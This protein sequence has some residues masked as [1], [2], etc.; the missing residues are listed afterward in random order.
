MKKVEFA[1]GFYAELSGPDRKG[2]RLIRL[3]TPDD[4]M[5]ASMPGTEETLFPMAHG[6]MYGY[7]CGF[8]DCKRKLKE[9]LIDAVNT[10]GPV[11]VRR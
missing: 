7:F 2:E 8:R 5:A 10:V 4:V 1:N 3:Y 9:K 6:M 11:D